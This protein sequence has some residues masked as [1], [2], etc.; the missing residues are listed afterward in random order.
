MLTLWANFKIIRNVNDYNMHHKKI[1][2]KKKKIG[3]DLMEARSQRVGKNERR[4]Y[5]VR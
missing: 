2:K 5:S 4:N 3:M 1:E